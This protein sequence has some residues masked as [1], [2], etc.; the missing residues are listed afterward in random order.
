VIRTVSPAMT[1][2]VDTVSLGATIGYGSAA[3]A[4]PAAGTSIPEA[5]SASASR[6]HVVR[7]TFLRTQY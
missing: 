5:T 6:R 4:T 7:I 3:T 1:V 2:D